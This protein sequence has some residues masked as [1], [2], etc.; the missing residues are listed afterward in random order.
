MA[1]PNLILAKN[2]NGKDAAWGRIS[3]VNEG[4]GIIRPP[5][6]SKIAAVIVLGYF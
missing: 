2:G 4:I 5:L 1:Y 6:L 3:I